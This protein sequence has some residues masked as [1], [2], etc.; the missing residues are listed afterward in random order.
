LS[1]ILLAVAGL[2]ALLE[3]HRRQ[4]VVSAGEFALDGSGTPLSANDLHQRY[5]D[6]QEFAKLCA[7]VQEHYDA[8][9]G[10]SLRLQHLRKNRVTE[11]DRRKQPISIVE[12]RE[13]IHFEGRKECPTILET[14]QVLGRSSSPPQEGPQGGLNIKAPFSSEVPEGFYRYQ[15]E[16]VEKVAGQLV[17][18]VHFEPIKPIEGSFKGS[19]WIDPSTSEPIRMHGSAVKLLMPLDRLEMLIDYGPAENGYNQMRRATVDVVGGFAFIF[20]HYR[21]E[22][23]LNHYQPCE[24]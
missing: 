6:P 7:A 19:V 13:R 18:R 24:Q 11:F 9:V 10:R 15:F 2:L 14:R 23:E 8:L 5:S 4:E 3:W 20:K 12:T 17:L 1:C 21:I 22:A 16:S